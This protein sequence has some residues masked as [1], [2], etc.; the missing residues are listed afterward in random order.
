MTDVPEQ[1]RLATV[2]DDVLFQKLGDEFV[3]ANL[4]TGVYVTLDELAARIWELLKEATSLD[5]LVATLLDEYEV[6]EVT[7]RSDLQ[8]LFKKFREFGLMQFNCA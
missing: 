5:T 2:P 3:V 4:D 1:G 6:D 7:L 8:E